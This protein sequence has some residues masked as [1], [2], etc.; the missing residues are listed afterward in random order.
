MPA[1]VLTSASHGTQP[2]TPNPCFRYDALGQVCS[3]YPPLTFS[4]RQHV[5]NTFRIFDVFERVMLGQ[6]SNEV[7]LMGMGLTYFPREILQCTQLQVMMHDD[8]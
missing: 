7:T 3:C 6:K 4:R 8:A 5:E 2:T 1:R